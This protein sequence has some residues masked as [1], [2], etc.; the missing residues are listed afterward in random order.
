MAIRITADMDMIPI[1]TDTIRTP[2][3][4][5]AIRRL[6]LR[7]TGTSSIRSRVTRSKAT[8]S[9]AT[10]NRATRNRAT[11]NRDIHSKD[12]L[13]RQRPLLPRR[14]PNPRPGAFRDRIST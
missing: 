7:I 5:Q 4:I 2:T 6:L 3:A 12:N 14:S 13:N 11:R 10:R 1:R 8:R 9:K